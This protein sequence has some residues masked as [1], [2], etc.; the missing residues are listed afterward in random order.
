MRS[1]GKVKE[2]R[3]P[4]LIPRLA[5]KPTPDPTDLSR[6]KRIYYLTKEQDFDCSD[7]WRV[8]LTGPLISRLS[9]NDAKTVRIALA[10]QDADWLP[11][12]PHTT[13]SRS[14]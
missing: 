11:S 2:G 10:D 8:G 12:D 13:M 6:P 3:R 5:V 7:F 14:V 4:T 9:T 1:G